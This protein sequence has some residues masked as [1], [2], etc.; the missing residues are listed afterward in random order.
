LTASIGARE[1][2]A[3]HDITAKRA[4]EVIAQ[5]PLLFPPAKEPCTATP[6]NS[7]SA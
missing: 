3:L 1:G 2:T 4:I 7:C 5:E 6:D